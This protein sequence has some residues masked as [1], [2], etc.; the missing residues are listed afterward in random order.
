MNIIDVIILLLI[1]IPALFGF[2][3]GFLK[4]IFTL[5]S[6]VAGIYFAT[7]FHSNI[8]VLTGYIIKDEKL[9]NLISFILI[10]LF[11]YLIGVYISKK[12]SGINKL[13]KALDKTLGLCFGLLKGIILVSLLTLGLIA[14]NFLPEKEKKESVLFPYV[15][16]V[17]PVTYDI[18][19]GIFFSSGK[20]FL[21]K[22]NFFGKDTTKV[23]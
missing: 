4:S 9:S 20:S 1:G 16:K 13:T 6:I 14:Y 3:K 12:L 22:N 7:K 19:S 10:I 17:S 18:I 11:V 8:N 2:R 5:I 21:E 15:V 23:K